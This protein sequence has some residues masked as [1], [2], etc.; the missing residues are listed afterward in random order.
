MSD[1]V[2]SIV[3]LT[4]AEYRKMKAEITVFNHFAVKYR[5]HIDEQ[6]VEVARLTAENEKLREALASIDELFSEAA[7]DDCEN[8]VRWLNEQAASKYLAEY[9]HTRA[10]ISFAHKV[11]RAALSGDKQ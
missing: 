5:A 8:G 6:N 9:P 7:Q 1:I 11:A 10:A 3:M 4:G 2:D